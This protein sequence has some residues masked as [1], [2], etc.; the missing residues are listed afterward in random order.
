MIRRC[1]MKSLA[2]VLALIVPI[3]ATA[4]ESLVD[5]LLR[6]SGLTVAPQ[7]RGPGDEGE[8]GNLWIVDLD[9]RASR[10]L[11]A[12]GGYRSPVFAPGGVIY[13]LKAATIVRIPLD[14]GKPAT[15]Q[16]AAGALKLAGFDRTDAD[17][18]LV[19]FESAAAGSPLGVVSLKT[20][21]LTPLP[22]DAKS[23]EQRLMLEQVR[24]QDRV[25]GDTSLYTKTE[26]K[27]GLSRNIE[28]TDVYLRRGAAAPQNI[29]ACDGMNCT[30]PALA[31]DGRNVVFVKT[32]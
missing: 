15:V 29:S 3:H 18:L 1:Q 14:G 12:D 31:P 19:L 5:R 32:E 7:T 4:A 9:R 10:A 22:Y 13:A 6:I 8:A 30:Q 23:A 21:R 24:A 28:W 20:G 2:A 16:K 26:S 11:T 25:Y 17:E 27:R